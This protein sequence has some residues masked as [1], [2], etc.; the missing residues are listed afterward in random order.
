MVGRVGLAVAAMATTSIITFSPSLASAATPPCTTTCYVSAAGG[1]DAFGGGSATSAKK[2]IQ[3]AIDAVDVGGQVRVMPGIYHEVAA[4]RAPTT[5]GGIYQFGLFFGSG[6]PGISLVGVTAGDV[7]ITSANATKATINTDATNSFGTD[8][9]FVEAA[10]TTIQGVKIGP[11]DSGDNKTIEVVA[12]NFTLRYATTAI[13]NGGGSIYI[14]DFSTAGDVVKGY[15]IIDNVFPDGTSV[16]IASGA[17]STGPVADR[18]ILG[19]TFDLGDNG[20]NA[21]SFS[22]SGGVAWFVNPVGGAIIK[23]NSFANSTQ[24]IRARGIYAES[25][26]DWASIGTTTRST[27]RPSLW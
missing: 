12:D 2:T 10:N 22:G 4:N 7:P 25:E 3:A 24:F 16:D 21:I 9:I 27:R 8:G 17:G 14:D 26:F 18:E 6:K 15:H 5:V 13:P 19:N 23:N 1:N 11:N 20:Y